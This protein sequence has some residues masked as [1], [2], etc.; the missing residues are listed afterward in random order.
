MLTVVLAT[1]G[2]RHLAR[3]LAALNAIDAPCQW[4]LVIAHNGADQAE[5]VALRSLVERFARH[6]PIQYVYEPRRGKNYGCNAAIPHIEGDLAVF[7]DDDVVPARDWLVRLYETAATKPDYDIFGGRIVPLWPRP[8]EPYLLESVP[9][10]IVFGISPDDWTEGPSEPWKMWGGN[11]AFRT[12]IFAAGHRFNT[13]VGPDGT[14]TYVM[15]SKTEFVERLAKAGHRCWYVPSAVVQHIIREEQFDR[16]WILRRAFRYGRFEGRM[17]ALASPDSFGP[18]RT[19][20]SCAMLI[21]AH[22]CRAA[23]YWLRRDPRRLRAEFKIR[24]LYGKARE[25]ARFMRVPNHVRAAQARK[26]GE[27]EKRA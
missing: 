14:A 4:K 12:R 11:V 15:G 10:T 17:A 24:L 21:P 20:A 25:A 7:T 18:H 23:Y 16:D 19:L 5:S 22:L 3:T 6:V 27:L 9:I 2:Q 8:P 13:S 1:L 26:V